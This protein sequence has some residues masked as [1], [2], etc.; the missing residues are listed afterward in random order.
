MFCF[1]Y[2]ML[3]NS[4]GRSVV[5][6][7]NLTNTSCMHRSGSTS[8]GVGLRHHVKVARQ[9]EDVYE[10]GESKRNHCPCSLSPASQ[11][12]WRRLCD[13]HRITL[14]FPVST[15]HALATVC[16]TSAC[17]SQR[18]WM[19]ITASASP[20]TCASVFTGS[21]VCFSRTP[22]TM[23]KHIQHI[24]LHTHTYVYTHTHTC[25]YTCT[26]SHTQTH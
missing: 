14:L 18:L 3:H 16:Y 6:Y 17:A 12:T 21:A 10:G 1:D 9:G 20:S 22:A 15:S 4:L 8:P 11:N 24:H 25:A 13:A 5:A 7:Y 19:E 26:L 2:L 23:R